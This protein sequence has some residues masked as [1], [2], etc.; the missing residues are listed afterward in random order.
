MK[1]IDKYDRDNFG[2]TAKQERAIVLKVSGL[3][4]TEIANELKIDRGTLYS[5]SK[6]ENF[7]SFFAFLTNECRSNMINGLLGM[8]EELIQ[9]LRDSLNSENDSV[10]FKAATWLYEKIWEM[11]FGSDNPYSRIESISR[12][13]EWNT[14][15]GTIDDD[16]YQSLISKNNL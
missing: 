4:N 3:S 12:K 15:M 1:T 11:N 13:N 9:G 10:K 8:H 14:P 16:L 6:K 2:L 7:Q 5:W